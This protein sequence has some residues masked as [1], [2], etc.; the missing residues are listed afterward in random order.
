[1]ILLRYYLKIVSNVAFSSTTCYHDGLQVPTGA[2]PLSSATS[3]TDKRNACSRILNNKEFI[4]RSIPSI[5][6]L[7]RL[8][9]HYSTSFFSIS[10]FFFFFESSTSKSSEYFFIEKVLVIACTINHI[11]CRYI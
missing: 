10:F 3:Y 6:L 7:T 1:M 4:S 9:C 11:R 2:T 8:V 5:L